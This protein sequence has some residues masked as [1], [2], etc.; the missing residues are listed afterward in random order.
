MLLGV[1][2]LLQTERS[3]RH[4]PSSVDGIVARTAASRKLGYR[5]LSHGRLTDKHKF[6]DQG[7]D[8]LT[9]DEHGYLDATDRGVTVVN[10]EGE[11]ILSIQTPQNPANL[12][13]GGKDSVA[14]QLL[15]VTLDQ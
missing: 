15:R 12:V 2:A 8:G 14:R 4:D 3:V 11:R 5:I 7:S 10:P 9:L 1:L 6:A 13:F